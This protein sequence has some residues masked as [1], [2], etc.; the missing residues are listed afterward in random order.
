MTIAQEKKLLAEDIEALLKKDYIQAHELT[1]RRL[2]ELA[3]DMESDFFTVVVLGEFKRG[4]STFINAMLGESLLPVDVLPET[5][6][7]NALIYDESPQVEVVMNDGTVKRGQATR[8]YLD[9]FSARNRDSQADKVKYIKIGYPAKVLQNRTV[10][11]DTPGV[12]DIN[13]QRCEV[14]YRFIPKANAVLFLLDANSPL[15]KTEKDFIDEKL[16][17]LGIDNIIFVLNKYDQVDE[18][19][20]GEDFLEEL[21]YR[22]AEAFGVGTSEET[23]S[24]IR[25]YPLS[26]KMALMGRETKNEAMIRASGICE[27]EQAI[28]EVVY[29]GSVEQEKLSRYKGRL[30]E[31]LNMLYRAMAEEKALQT[32]DAES[33]RQAAQKLDELIAEQEGHQGN[34]AEYASSQQ[35]NMIAMVNKSIQYFHRRL[36]ENV[37]DMVAGYHGMDFKNF[38]EQRVSKQLQR[39]MENWV[40]AYSP[41]VDRLLQM[42]ERELANGISYRFRQKVEVSTD[43]LGHFRQGRTLFDISAQDVSD[44]NMKAGIITA[45]GAGLMMLI[46]GPILLPFISMAAFPFLQKKILED[47]LATAKDAVIPAIQEQIAGAVYKLRQSIY[48]HIKQ[49]TGQIVQNMEYV[50]DMILNDLKERVQTSIREKEEHEANITQTVET[51]DA[52]MNDMMRIMNRW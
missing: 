48:D 13:E 50:Y 21:Q 40:A 16:L 28:G 47:K 22:L 35:D 34:I 43:G 32:A 12:S 26:A 23:L 9:A 31:S 44:A 33:L 38:V 11:V 1:M 30:K 37:V 4:K 39:E 7:I 18:E 25:L 27:L 49:K 51:I 6:T 5:A 29:G 36:E 8:E 41:H 2:E 42:L 19:E 15:K 46:G 17:P 20:E 14:T 52:N 3:R 45:G 10:I 24:K